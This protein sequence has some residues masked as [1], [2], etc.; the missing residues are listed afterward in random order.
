MEIDDVIQYLSQINFELEANMS[1]KISPDISRIK[2]EILDLS[3]MQR[4]R[5]SALFLVPCCA[6]C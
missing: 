5:C 1:D 6:G 2:P 3:A 4:V